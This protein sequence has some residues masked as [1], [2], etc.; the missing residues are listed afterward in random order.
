[1]I[2][3]AFL[4]QEDR[5][6][7]RLERHSERAQSSKQPMKQPT[8]DQTPSQERGD[9]ENAADLQHLIA[10]TLAIEGPVAPA[11]HG[12]KQHDRMRQTAPEPVGIADNAVEH[13]S[14]NEDNEDFGR[15]EGVRSGEVRAAQGVRQTCIA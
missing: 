7:D 12:A 2:G 1:M 9:D 3:K 11:D 5:D 4:G 15:H 10:Q 13:Q 14:G 6:E 8:A